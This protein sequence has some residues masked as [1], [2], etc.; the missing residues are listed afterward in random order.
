MGF[1]RSNTNKSAS[2]TESQPTYAEEQDGGYDA[3]HSRIPQ[4]TAR[5]YP[6]PPMHN[7]SP[8]PP[9]RPSQQARMRQPH[10][11][12]QQQPYPG[13]EEYDDENEEP[14]YSD[15]E[16][17]QAAPVPQRR[18]QRARDAPPPTYAS[19]PPYA[20][21][22][23]DK[24]PEHAMGSVHTRKDYPLGFSIDKVIKN[25]AD[26]YDNIDPAKKAELKKKGFAVAKTLGTKALAM[27]KSHPPA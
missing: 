1:L 24:V 21:V 10:Q 27:A 13:D 4:M 22:Y 7:H 17:I 15:E 20:P 26:R 9:S 16:E 3:P 2:S 11:Q 6:P 23:N 12:P 5:G 18:Q 19:I 14:V 8:Y 25:V